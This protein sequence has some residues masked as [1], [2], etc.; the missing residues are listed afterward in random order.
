VLGP[1]GRHDPVGW[2]ECVSLRGPSRER[3]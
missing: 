3:Q 1:Q 2:I